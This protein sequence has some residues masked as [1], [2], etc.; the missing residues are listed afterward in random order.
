MV[1]FKAGF[2]KKNSFINANQSEK[3]LFIV[4]T[5]QNKGLRIKSM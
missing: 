2:L 1:W 3:A 4:L 5:N